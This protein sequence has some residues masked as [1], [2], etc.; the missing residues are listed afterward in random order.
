[1]IQGLKSLIF[2]VAARTIYFGHSILLR[3]LSG[4]TLHSGWIQKKL[5]GMNLSSL[6]LLLL[7]LCSAILTGCSYLPA[8]PY[9]INI[10][11]GNVVTEE[12][13]VKLKMGM[14]RSQVRFALGSPLI[15]DPFHHNR[16]DY[17]YRLAPSGRVSEEKRLTILFEND[18]LTRIDGDFPVP[19][20]FSEAE[21]I[22]PASGQPFDS[23]ENPNRLPQGEVNDSRAVDFMK[24][25]QDEFYRG[26]E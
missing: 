11:Q 15:T 26:R 24:K 16:W 7:L 13:I 12:M 18:R 19:A 8:F 3:Y 20:T 2:W 5:P 17:V 9:R 21:E 14:T 10:Q 22:I 23:I 6:P 4:F 25:N 1:M